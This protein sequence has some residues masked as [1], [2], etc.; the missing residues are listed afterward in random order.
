MASTSF[1]LPLFTFGCV[2][3][4]SGAVLAGL[5][6]VGE[7]VLCAVSVVGLV[8][9]AGTGGA[10]VCVGRNSFQ[11]EDTT[12]FVKALCAVVHDNTDPEKALGKKQ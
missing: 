3:G 2:P 11:R 12:A 4:V 10:G 1:L 7:S 5:E 9:A 6:G 8:P